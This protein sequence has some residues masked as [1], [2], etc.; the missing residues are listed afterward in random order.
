MDN[1][2]WARLHGASTH[3]PIALIMASTLFDLAG[4]FLHDQAQRMRLQA[5]GF[6]TLMLGAAGA[7]VAVISGLMLSRGELVGQGS[8]ARHHL[9]IWPAFGLMIGLAVWRM[10]VRE[11]SSNRTFKVYLAFSMVAVGLTAGA[12]YWGGE[13]LL[14]H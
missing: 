8:L 12:G 5:T 4:C 14:N 11:R 3:F 9:F 10:V 13:L 1:S 6:H 7:M 2:L